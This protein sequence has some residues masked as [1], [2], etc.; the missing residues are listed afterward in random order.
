MRGNQPKNLIKTAPKMRK[1][2]N[3]KIGWNQF[4]WDKHLL[5]LVINLNFMLNS[6]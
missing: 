4:N 2:K 5:L 1:K 6:H 3:Q